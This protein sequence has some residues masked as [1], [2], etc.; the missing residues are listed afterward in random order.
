MSTCR[1]TAA[2]AAVLCL[3]TGCT[4]T[5][6]PPADPDRVVVNPPA[7]GEGHTHA[8][9]ETDAGPIGDG[10]RATAGGY[11]LD[12]VRL[13]GRAGAPGDVRFRVLGRDG[14]PVTDYVEE[15]TKLLHLYV[16]RTDLAVF[17]HLHPVL[18]D[19]T[20]TARADLGEPGDYRVITE[21]RPAATERPV[22]LG[23][24]VTVP[25]RWRSAGVPPAGEQT[26]DDGVVRVAAVGPGEVGRDG[27][28]R[29]AVT[30]VDGNP[31]TLGSYLGTSA[32]VTGFVVGSGGF[33]HVH[34]YGAPETTQDGTVLTFH[35]AFEE[36]GDYRF[37][38]QVRVDGFLHT[39]PVTVP[40]S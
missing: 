23:T 35:T 21:F 20:W 6:G 9:G 17:R 39:V 19:G 38:V 32:H 34:P 28:L 12:A 16:V 3:A 33:V 22:L 7:E 8:P 40:V 1:L 2:V 29:L 14:R 25:G 36:A 4:G 11:R 30:D 5:E 24:T 10:T 15:Q 18:D 26:S 27:R 13:P 31:L 37:F